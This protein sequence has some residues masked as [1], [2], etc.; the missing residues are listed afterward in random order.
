MTDWIIFTDLDGT[1]LHHETYAFEAAESAL[2]KI[3][4]LN[5]PLIINSSKTAA[6]IR[7][8]CQKLHLNSAFITENGA[9]IYLA[10][11]KY[12]TDKPKYQK[13]IL[14]TPYHEIITT[15]T[16]LREQYHFNFQGFNDFSA[17][18]LAQLT[19]LSQN[20]AKD[21][22]QRSGSE[23]ILWQDTET[24]KQLFE[25][26]LEQKQLRLVQ[27]GRFDHVM[28]HNDKAKAMAWL[29]DKLFKNSPPKTLALGDSPNDL[30]MLEQAE[31]SAVICKPDGSHLKIQK[32]P[33]QIY[34][35]RQC[36]PEG[37]QE[38]IDFVLAKLNLQESYHE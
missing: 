19:G 34:Y 36:A 26:L 15:L 11:L 27:G 29:L 18:K 37:W 20:E 35:A 17:P 3:R 16:S 33:D 8:F 25:Q 9:C 14:G 2:A 22:K 23:P 32:H 6:E 7:K 1:L 30:A 31:F 28:G 21:A 5:I 10:D 4:V 13:V 12:K 38:S 24:R